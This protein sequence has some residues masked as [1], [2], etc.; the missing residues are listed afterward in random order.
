M[1]YHVFVDMDGVLCDFVGGLARRWVL[2]PEE[3]KKTWPTG[4]YDIL[5][6][7]QIASKIQTRRQLKASNRTLW[8]S[9]KGDWKFWYNLPK[10]DSGEYLIHLLDNLGISWSIVTCPSYDPDCLKGKVMWLQHH[11]GKDFRNYFICTQKD[12]LAGA[13][14]VLV[15]DKGLNTEEFT[16]AGGLGV[17]WPQPWNSNHGQNYKDILEHLMFVMK[18]GATLEND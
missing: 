18:F 14:R 6:G 3:T 4:S 7:L 10:L 16:A 5:F 2:D 1:K 15:D 12:L 9:I 17:L 8:D 11:F 13:D